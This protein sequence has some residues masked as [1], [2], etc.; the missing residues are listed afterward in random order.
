MRKPI[1]IIFPGM[2]TSTFLEIINFMKLRIGTSSYFE[3]TL[4]NFLRTSFDS[5]VEV[6]N[7][8]V[9]FNLKLYN[10]INL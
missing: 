1:L 7:V 5:R 9:E 2:S 3:M 6:H 4:I 10:G 8:K